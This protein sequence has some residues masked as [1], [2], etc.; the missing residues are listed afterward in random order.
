MD[1]NDSTPD[2]LRTTRREAAIRPAF[3]LYGN[4]R[5][6]V[7]DPQQHEL[8]TLTE[9]LMRTFSRDTELGFTLVG[10]WDQA[11]GL[12]FA[13]GR[14]LERFHDALRPQSAGARSGGNE[15]Y[16]LGETAATQPATTTPTGLYTDP[17]EAFAAMRTVM[18]RS[19]ERPVF[20]VDWN[21]LAVTQAASPDPE[22]R[23]RLLQLGKAIL[24]DA[25]SPM[26][27]DHLRQS[28]GLIVLIA[29]QLGRVPP[30]LYQGDPRIRLI[31]VPTASRAERVAFFRRHADDLRCERPRAA[32][33]T[34][35][36]APQNGDA[37]AEVLAD[38]TDQ[39][40]MADLRQLISLSLGTPQPLAP[41]RL[42]NLYRF[43]DQR[44]PWEELSE[45]KL[46]RVE[47]L[48]KQRVVGQDQAVRQVATMTVRA[49]MGLAGMQHSSRHSKPKGTL[50]FVGPTGVGKTELA[51]ACAEFL[52]GDESANIRFDMSEY[53]HEHSDQRLV[54]APPGYVGFEEGGQ[55]TNAVR[56]RPFSVLLFDEIEKAH[57]RVLDKFL[58]ILEDGR[59][60][61][62]RGETAHFS[63]CVI[64]FTSNIGAANVP[65]TTDPAVVQTHFVRAVEDHF[66]RELKRPELLNRLGD[67]IAVFQ[68]IA[69]DAI[70]RLILVK[71]LGPLRA[72]LQERYGVTLRI[73]PELEE[74]YL[75]GARAEHGGRGL[76]NV[77][78]RDLLNP[79]AWFLFERKHQLRRG[80]IIAAT[81]AGDSVAFDL[82]EA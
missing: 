1:R 65:E 11:D 6:L 41:Q 22:E 53:N 27:S 10:V 69:S 46:R 44:S 17:L 39:L 24:G 58:Q 51:K 73:A 30:V 76:V 77:L 26:D 21:H 4:V 81:P 79:L 75:R 31:A 3:I 48:L 78:E 68:P 33:E 29:A 59:L 42:L 64:I 5:D 36:E 49:Y 9:F 55:L 8:V 14:M 18:Q 82:Q 71:T 13:N 63:E 66:V 72:H 60:T 43:G 57:P 35:T 62:G 40:T 47:E 67:N 56:Q 32:S 34:G 7:Y 25:V 23:Q 28:R 70:R 12:R 61:D 20:L 80:R 74:R 16:K 19:T 45:E 52:F 2:W 38:L 50:F 15:A 37:L 54:G